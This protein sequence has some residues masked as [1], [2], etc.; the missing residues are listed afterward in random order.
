MLTRRSL[1][2]SAATFGLS[3]LVP[4]FDGSA[5]GVVPEAR[6]D[7]ATASD[8]S[9][10]GRER[11]LLEPEWLENLKYDLDCVEVVARFGSP[12]KRP[13]WIVAEPMRRTS[14]CPF[15]DEAGFRVGAESFT[16]K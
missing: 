14:H 1:F 3:A 12:L 6:H 9:H 8:D 4:W 7:Y 10:S 2:K 13:R 16:C 11:S 15:C 5:H